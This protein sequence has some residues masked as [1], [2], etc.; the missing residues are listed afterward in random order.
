MEHQRPPLQKDIIVT[1]LENKIFNIS[2]PPVGFQQYLVLGENR[3]ML[4][5]TG[6]GIGSLKRIVEAV[7]EL[8]ITLVN[9]HCH[10]DHAG[11][12]AEFGPALINPADLDV[13]YQMASREFRVQ[14]VSRMP[15]GAEWASQLQPTGPEPVPAY[16]GQMIDLGGRKLQIF[17]TPGHTHGSL[18]VFD[19]MT[20]TLFT[21]DNVQANATALIEWNASSV[22]EFY[23]SLCK[24]D[25]LPVKRLLSGH[26]PNDNPPDLL[27]RKMACAEQILNGAEGVE[28]MHR[29]QTAYEFTWQ[30]TAILY[31]KDRI[32]K[33][34]R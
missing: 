13:F 25:Q 22:E 9:T 31:R 19:W 32:C 30:G 3:A 6:I 11:G 1:D 12:N 23:D 27:R 15:G 26:R 33:E 14:D 4:I 2:T 28:K 29:G 34:I 21:G 24:L 16:D 17:F 20:G 8:P 10:P 5:D 18:C 7:T